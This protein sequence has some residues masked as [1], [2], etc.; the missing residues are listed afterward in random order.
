MAANDSGVTA[1]VDGESAAKH[2]LHMV[3]MEA[4]YHEAALVE[5]ITLR[6]DSN[7]D[8]VEDD[9]YTT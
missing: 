9:R 2:T 4:M 3:R 1:G 5:T 7:L 8:R 6:D